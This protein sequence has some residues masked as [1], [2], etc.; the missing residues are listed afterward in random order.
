[1]HMRGTKITTTRPPGKTIGTST[2]FC[3]KGQAG[4][5]S[6]A[7][8]PRKKNN[9]KNCFAITSSFDWKAKEPVIKEAQRYLYL[10][11]DGPLTVTLSSGE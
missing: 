10:S 3:H 6:S 11:L 9:T 5:P 2:K 4:H 8:W 1:M 7:L